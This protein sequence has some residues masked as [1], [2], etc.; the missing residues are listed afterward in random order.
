MRDMTLEELAA[1]EGI[2]SESLIQ[3]KQHLESG[4]LILWLDSP[5]HVLLPND[6]SARIDAL[7]QRLQ[8]RDKLTKKEGAYLLSLIPASLG[9]LSRMAKQPKRLLTLSHIPEAR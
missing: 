5:A 8:Q 9:E 6:D 7:L 3:L 2:P 4:G 1:K